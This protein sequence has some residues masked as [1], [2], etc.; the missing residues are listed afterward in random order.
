MSVRALLF[1]HAEGHDLTQACRVRGRRGVRVAAQGAAHG[2]GAGDRGAARGGRA[3]TGGAGFPMGRKASFLPKPDQTTKP[4]YLAVNADESEPG[5]CKDREIM[6]RLPHMV[7]EGVVIA[8]YAIQAKA[9]FIY[10]R[11]EYLTEFEIM[12]AALEE[13]QARGLV[14]GNVLGSGYSV[15]V[16]LHRGAGAYICGE[17]TGLLESLEGKRGQPRSKPPFPAISGLYAAPTLIN[18]VETLATVP[19]ILELGGVAL[20]GAGRRELDGHPR[21]LPLGQRGTARQLRAGAGNEPARARLRAG[22]RRPGRPRAEGDH[23]GRL[24]RSRARPRPRWTRRSTSTRWRRPA[25]CWA[26]APSS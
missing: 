18:N 4:I 24:V 21:L 8:S 3:G 10:I 22:R 13:A 20:R 5:T 26:R 25:R 11:G 17:E 7:I 2:A 16:V 19:K 12:K 1:E 14:G 6:Q 15:S 23:P 9:A